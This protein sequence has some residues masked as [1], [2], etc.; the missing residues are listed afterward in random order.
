MRRDAEA[1]AE[2]DARASGHGQPQP[3]LQ[4]RRALTPIWIGAQRER[5]AN[6]RGAASRIVAATLQIVAAARAVDTS[7]RIELSLHRSY[8]MQWLTKSRLDR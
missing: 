6:V 2:R 5:R 3:V 7:F 8:S 4:Q 1:A